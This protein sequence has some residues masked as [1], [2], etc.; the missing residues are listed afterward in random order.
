MRIVCVTSCYTGIVHTYMAA[1]A[2]EI[3]GTT[4]GHEVLVE[5]Q[6][7]AGSDH[8]TQGVID[9]ADGVIF[10]VDL[11]VID[12]DRFAGKPY[13]EVNVAAAIN[14]SVEIMEEL[15]ARITDGT[16]ARFVAADKLAESALSVSGNKPPKKGFFARLFGWGR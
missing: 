15:I 12:R 8:F 3:A 2:L 6:G 9:S 14:G 1:E 4:L 16:A 7:S 11:E 10:A 13:L 5:T